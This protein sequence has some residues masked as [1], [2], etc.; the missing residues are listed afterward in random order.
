MPGVTDVHDPNHGLAFH[1]NTK[2]APEDGG[3]D[4]HR[5]IAEWQ[6][7]NEKKKQRLV[8]CYA[9]QMMRLKDPAA[10][11]GYKAEVAQSSPRMA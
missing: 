7:G 11:R 8:G 5:M 3:S 6:G 1:P 10:R 4:E 9:P 2:L